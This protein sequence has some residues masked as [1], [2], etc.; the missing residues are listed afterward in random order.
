MTHEAKIEK[1]FIGILTE[2]ENQWT[3]RSDIKTEAALWENLRGH[4]DR[5][6]LR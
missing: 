2:R 4:I 1:D 5:I 6:S 3:Y